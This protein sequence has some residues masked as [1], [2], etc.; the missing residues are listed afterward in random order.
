[1]VGLGVLSLN[2]LICPLKQNL[3]FS[4]QPQIQKSTHEY[5]DLKQNSLLAIMDEINEMNGINEMDELEIDSFINEINYFAINSKQKEQKKIIKEVIDEANPKDYFDS[6]LKNNRIKLFNYGKSII[7]VRKW[8]RSGCICGNKIYSQGLHRINFCIDRFRL[9]SDYQNF[10]CL[11]VV[12]SDKRRKFINDGYW[13][14]TFYFMTHWHPFIE[15]ENENK[16]ENNVEKEKEKGNE[17]EK[18]KGKGKGKGKGKEQQ[19][20]KKKLLNYKCKKFPEIQEE[21][22]RPISEGDIFTI[23]LDM[24]RKQ[25]SF[26][27]NQEDFGIAWTNIPN[28]VC[29]FACLSG[30]KDTNNKNQISLL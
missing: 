19:E 14:Q 24:D 9:S 10:I 25:M 26:L 1:M 11:G 16:N 18:E 6:K 15:N 20:P 3:Q 28:N 29:F 7:T 12:D 30:Q 5:Q 22:A 8:K 13:E 21:F 4:I 27:I 17:N 23:H 2:T